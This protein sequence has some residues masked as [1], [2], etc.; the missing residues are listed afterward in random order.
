MEKN[1]IVIK[2]V[3]PVLAI[4]LLIITMLS[5]IV[6][7]ANNTS[8]MKVGEEYKYTGLVLTVYKT[9]KAAKKSNIFLIKKTLGKNSEIKIEAISGN[10]IKIGKDQYIKCTNAVLKKLKKVANTETKKNVTA[11]SLDKEAYLDIT[12]P[13]IKLTA[14][15]TPSNLNNK[16]IEWTSS[17]PKVATVDQNGTVTRVGE[18]TTNIIAKVDGKQATC[19][20]T[21]KKEKLIICGPSTVAQLA[22]KRKISEEGEQAKYWKVDYKKEYGYTLN[23]DLYFICEPG[24]GLRYFAGT[25]YK[26][27]RISEKVNNKE[28][29]NS[30]HNGVG[31]KK[32]KEILTD[33]NNVNCHF[34]VIFVGSGNDL[35]QANM[36]QKTVGNIAKIYANYLDKLSSEYPEHT[37]YV[38][39]ATPIDEKSIDRKNSDEAKLLKQSYAAENSNNKKR[40]EFAVVL[41][42]EI[43]GKSRNNL[44]YSR[45]VFIDLLR[46]SG[47]KHGV[48][49]NEGKRENFGEHGYSGKVGRYN[50]FDGKHYTANGC[51][52]MMEELLKRAGVVD[53][54]L[55]KK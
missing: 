36:T 19:K 15:I 11:V 8:S 18:G 40:F 7:A 41:K 48:V 2:K 25:K 50:C 3:L 21:V 12:K 29:F 38:F 14:K 4:T 23:E 51:K 47:Y 17:N 20:V 16:K 13:S 39:P 31:G 22:G 6:Q 9:E 10:I 46:A 45:G 32:L 55:K 28:C 53:N 49:I 34:T 1:F 54:N 44:K 26:N 42:R 27:I 5:P 33:K 35:T 52:F 30:V 43:T 24:R 37:F